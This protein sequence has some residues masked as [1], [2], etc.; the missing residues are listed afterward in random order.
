MSNCCYGLTSC[1]IS[2]NLLDGCINC[3]K[4][5]MHKNYRKIECDCVY[6]GKH[7]CNDIM[8]CSRGIVCYKCKRCNH[9]RAYASCNE[10]SSTITHES[11]NF[12]T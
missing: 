6:D 12:L 11:N 4:C 9:H 5:S 2:R 10:C 7:G 1:D 8:V 3:G